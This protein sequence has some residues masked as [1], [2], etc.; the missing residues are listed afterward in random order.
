MGIQGRIAVW[1]IL[2]STLIL[3]SAQGLAFEAEAIPG[4]YLVKFKNS[5]SNQIL[6]SEEVY[7]NR[8]VIPEENLFVIKR[9]I[10]E[11]QDYVIK[12]VQQHPSVEYVEPN[13]VYRT[14]KVPNDP[15]FGKLWGLSNLGQSDGKNMGIAGFDLDAVRAWDLT[16]GSSEVI[17]AVID[18]GIDYNHPDLK[19]NMWTNQSELNGQTGIDD[20]GNGI[21]D[22]IYGANF[23]K[24]NEATGDPMDDHSHGTHCAGTI[25][26]KGDDGLGIVG[27]AWNVKLMAVKFLSKDGGGSLE[28]AIKAVDYATKMGAKISNNS[29]GGGGESQALREAIQ[30]AHLAGSLFVAAAGNSSSDNDKTPNFPSNYKVDNVLAVAAVDNQGKLA[31]FSS[32]GKRM[33]HVAA[34]GVNVYSS[35]LKEKYGSK[36][37]TSMATPHVAGL[38]V[39]LASAEPTLTHV[40][41]KERI[42][43]TAKT[44]DSVKQKVASRGMANAYAALTNTLTPPD[45]NDPENWQSVSS[46]VSSA[47][48]YAKNSNETFE[49][50][51]DGAKEI[52]IYFEKFESEKNYDK[53]T[54]YDSAGNKIEEISGSFSESY[55]RVIPGDSARLVFTSDESVER[56]GFDISKISFR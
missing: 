15:D 6:N 10:L 17:L 50:R 8:V 11:R 32:Y 46:A 38:A 16:T 39:L 53:L 25:G 5:S 48:P 45:L 7:E 47:H 29:W 21:V 37:G 56:Y 13:Y 31:S 42:I 22:D 54:I 23:V 3:Q 9:N 28:G 52:A 20:D 49:V 55:S 30:R 26:A 27:V 2:L 4:E 14:F 41:I 36:S 51:V 18:T 12:T 1:S 24:P 43:N 34:P 33:V 44:L 19:D 40:Q 35:V